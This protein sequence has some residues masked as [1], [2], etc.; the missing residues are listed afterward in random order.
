[1]TTRTA[2]HR[3]ALCR[4]RTRWLTVRQA[5]ISNRSKKSLRKRK[6]DYRSKIK[7]LN[8]DIHI[9]RDTLRR[10]ENEASEVKERNSNTSA[11]YNNLDESM[12]ERA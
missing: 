7:T 1:M 6:T 12:R 5:V 11:I 8:K 2:S 10:I 3:R 4:G 9:Y